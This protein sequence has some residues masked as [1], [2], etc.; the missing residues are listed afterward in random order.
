MPEG[1]DEGDADNMVRRIVLAKLAELLAQQMLTQ[2]AD[3]ET[4]VGYVVYI[5]ERTFEIKMMSEETDRQKDQEM[6]KVAHR[7][8]ILKLGRKK[9]EQ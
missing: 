5:T 3:L 6:A 1:K 7:K 9:S 8:G 4:T 2:E